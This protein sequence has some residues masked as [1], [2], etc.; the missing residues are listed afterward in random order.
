MSTWRLLELALRGSLGQLATDP[1]VHSFPFA[2]MTVRSHKRMLKVAMDG[3]IKWFRP[4]LQFRV[5]PRELRFL[6]PR[7]SGDSGV[8]A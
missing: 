8:A 5:A 1:N 4:P 6:T 7:E 2:T 3:E